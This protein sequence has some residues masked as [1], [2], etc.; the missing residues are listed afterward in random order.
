MF[1]F[2]CC[3]HQRDISTQRYSQESSLSPFLIYLQSG[4]VYIFGESV[5]PSGGDYKCFIWVYLQRALDNDTALILHNAQFIL[6]N[7]L[8]FQINTIPCTQLWRRKTINQFIITWNHLNK[9]F[10]VMSFWFMSVYLWFPSWPHCCCQTGTGN[11]L[12]SEAAIEEQNGTV[13]YL[14]LWNIQAKHGVLIHCLREGGRNTDAKN[15]YQYKIWCSPLKS[16]TGLFLFQF[17][18]MGPGNIA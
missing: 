2:F 15:I 4:S 18:N 5:A 1:A 13:T 9:F 8:H 12:H 16:L 17:N 3:C 11:N 14:V 10:Y 7:T 6:L